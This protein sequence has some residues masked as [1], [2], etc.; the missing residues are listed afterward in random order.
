MKPAGIV[1]SP[2]PG[3][4]EEAGISVELIKRLAG[5]VPILGVCLGHQAIAAAFGGQVVSAQRIVHG[6][7]E[8][9]SLDGRGLFRGLPRTA[10]FTR[11]HSLAAE[12]DIASRG[13]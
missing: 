13:A 3:R 11:Y 5:T 10:K 6:K 7:A 9:M 8:D 4:P 12:R 1:I 2:G